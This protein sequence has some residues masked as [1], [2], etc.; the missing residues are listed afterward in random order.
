MK[1]KFDNIHQKQDLMR[2]ANEIYHDFQAFEFNQVHKLRH[3]AEA[4]FWEKY[5]L[6]K[7]QRLPGTSIVDLCTGTGFVPSTLLPLLPER[8]IMS[9]MDIST[10]ALEQTEKRMGNLKERMSFKQGSAEELPFESESVD[11]VTLNAGLHH[12]PDWQACLKEVDRILKPDGLFC[13]G[14]EPNRLYFDSNL[15]V[16]IERTI[17]HF[18][19]YLSLEQ[20]FRRFKSLIGEKKNKASYELKEHLSEINRILTEE[21]L[22]SNPLTIDELRQYIDPHTHESEDEE[23]KTGFDPVRLK[24]EFF[25]GYHPEAAL[26]S[27]YGG[28]MLRKFPFIRHGFDRLMA[29][30]FKNQG[31]LFSLILKKDS[32]ES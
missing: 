15:L 20:N 21:K 9:C 11:C 26:F 19:W 6:N 4:E 12:I 10:K 2:R 8:F 29:T 27:D 16:K 28:E 13:L 23:G 30:W 5:A 24:E 31:R 32:K 14:H 7:I 3:K 1:T 17:W 25:P 22:I 18:F